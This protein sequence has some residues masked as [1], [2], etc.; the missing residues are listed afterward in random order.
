[1]DEKT[2][3]IS[4][5][6]PAEQAKTIVNEVSKSRKLPKFAKIAGIT[7]AGAVAGLGIFGLMGMTPPDPVDESG[8]AVDL[9]K[10]EIPESPVEA[11]GVT[12]DMSYAEAFKTARAEVGAGGYFEWKGQ[13]YG[14]MYETEMA[15]LSPEEQKQMLD[16]VMSEY[17]S[18]HTEPATEPAIVIHEVA[19]VAVGATD[20]MSF[21]DAFAVSRAEVGPGGVFEW[22]GDTY[23]TYTREEFAAMS[24]EQ[25]G[26]FIA[27][28][29]NEEIELPAISSSEVDILKIDGADEVVADATSGSNMIAEEI[30]TDPDTGA[31]VLVGLFEVDGELVIKVDSDGN[32][33]YDTNITQTEN[34]DYL[35]TNDAGESV[36]VTQADIESYQENMGI[37]STTDFDVTNNVDDVIYPTDNVENEGTVEVERPTD[38]VIYSTNDTGDFDNSNFNTD[39]DTNADTFMS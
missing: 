39:F 12:D 28:A 22:K 5:K 23:N 25:K 9:N 37:Y 19:P 24:E 4:S 18:S 8:N 35:L 31:N 34:G 38:D 7:G 3:L 30:I 11:T 36:T 32:G 1:M 14:T 20:D 29:G 16:N 17:H 21:K 27:S 26:E 15:Q 2:R 10:P 6:E 13:V 33:S